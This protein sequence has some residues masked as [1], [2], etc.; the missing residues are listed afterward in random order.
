MLAYRHSVNECD[1][2]LPS[3]R[4]QELIIIIIMINYNNNY[5]E[6]KYFSRQNIIAFCSNR[7]YFLIIMPR[8]FSDLL[9]ACI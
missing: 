9:R 5:C 1:S 4:V 7:Y 6:P 2:D 3:M 8:I